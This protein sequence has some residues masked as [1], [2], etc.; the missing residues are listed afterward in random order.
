MFRVEGGA[1]AVEA[2]PRTKY[3]K[4]RSYWIEYQRRELAKLGIDI[5][6]KREEDDDRPRFWIEE[7]KSSPFAGASWGDEIATRPRD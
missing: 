6:A 5:D 4:Y 2:W 3:L 1:E 7:D